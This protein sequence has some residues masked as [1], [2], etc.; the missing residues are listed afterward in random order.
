MYYLSLNNVLVLYRIY[1]VNSALCFRPRS[2]ILKIKLLHFPFTYLRKS[3]AI[4]IFQRKFSCLETYF[5]YRK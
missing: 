1:I 4:D 5:F 2:Q 3:Y